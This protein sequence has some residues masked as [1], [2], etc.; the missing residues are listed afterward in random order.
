MAVECVLMI[1]TASF[2]EIYSIPVILYHTIGAFKVMSPHTAVFLE[3]YLQNVY[4]DS[5]GPIM[6]MEVCKPMQLLLTLI[7]IS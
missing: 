3:G 6:L 2:K 4:L 7:S 5:V 1:F